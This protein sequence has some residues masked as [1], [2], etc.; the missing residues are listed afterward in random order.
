MAVAIQDATAGPSAIARLQTRLV[1][2]NA[3]VGWVAGLFRTPEVR[4][5]WIVATCF[6]S[7]FMQYL[8]LAKDLYLAGKMMELFGGSPNATVGFA[9]TLTSFLFFTGLANFLTMVCSDDFRRLEAWQRAAAVMLFPF[10][11]GYARFKV[12]QSQLKELAAY[13]KLRKLIETGPI[14]RSAVRRQ[15]AAIARVRKV[16]ESMGALWQKFRSNEAA[17][18]H[19]PTITTLTVL[20]AMSRYG[21]ETGLL[22]HEFLSRE[23]VSYAELSLVLS[24]FSFLRGMLSGF[25]QRHG[26]GGCRISAKIICLLL[27][28]SMIVQFQALSWATVHFQFEDHR[29]G[30]YYLTHGGA[31]HLKATKEAVF[32]VAGAENGSAVVVPFSQVLD[33]AIKHPREAIQNK[34]T[35]FDW[36]SGLDGGDA[37]KAAAATYFFGQ[38]ALPGVLPSFAL[39][40]A[41]F[42]ASQLLPIVAITFV[43]ML[44]MAVMP[45]S[46]LPKRR[47]RW[48]QHLRASWTIP[49]SLFV[50]HDWGDLLL[51]G[52][53]KS[54][55]KAWAKYSLPV[56]AMTALYAAVATASY[57]WY[58]ADVYRAIKAKNAAVVAAS[59]PLL[60]SELDREAHSARLILACAA[61]TG[62][63]VVFQ[64]VLL[65]LYFRFAHPW[66]RLL[67][68]KAN[69]LCPIVDWVG[70]RKDKEES[71]SD[72][73]LRNL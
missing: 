55:R 10:V 48:L 72:I 20:I 50:F 52:Q 58:F 13:E 5:T 34:Y 11:A 66:C 18:E 2:S 41:S 28:A 3:F 31:G 57:T 38:L 22:Q 73:E 56:Y 8:D 9:Y 36:H 68:E 30:L 6:V 7:A 64:I 16:R 12:G 14:E 42:M 44:C 4:R 62:V 23:M 29:R 1:E 17:F 67:A 15:E 65:S 69:A 49:V 59:L 46:E 26:G 63:L 25:E 45:L 19:F 47:E 39:H 21:A 61:G 53:C 33:S 27:A 60:K 54:V 51:S 40:P 43:S 37:D 71:T 70:A 24:Y 32:D 35:V